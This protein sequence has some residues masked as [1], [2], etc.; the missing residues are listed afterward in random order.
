MLFATI[1]RPHSSAYSGHQGDRGAKPAD[2]EAP[3]TKYAF[4]ARAALSVT[5][6]SLSSDPYLALTLKATSI[7]SPRLFLPSS[8]TQSRVLHTDDKRVLSG[9]L[10]WSK[11][12]PPGTSVLRSWSF[13]LCIQTPTIPLPR[14]QLFTI[15][16]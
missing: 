3:R 8:I 13:M 9:N 6:T 12:L 16:C 11:G 4:S 2:A 14:F 10:N 7:H 15:S 5:S 1:A